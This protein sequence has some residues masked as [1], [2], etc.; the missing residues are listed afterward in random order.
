MSSV[1]SKMTPTALMHLEDGIGTPGP[2]VL[3]CSPTLKYKFPS[4]FFRTLSCAH[5]TNTQQGQGSHSLCGDALRAAEQLLPP[6]APTMARTPL[7][8]HAT[9][10]DSHSQRKHLNKHFELYPN[11]L[12]NRSFPEVW[13]ISGLTCWLFHFSSVFSALTTVAK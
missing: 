1:A 12:H 4:G 9:L 13:E 11:S 3:L 5:F 7:L 10:E 8:C 6:T 2:W